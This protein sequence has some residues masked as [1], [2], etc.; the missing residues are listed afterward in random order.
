MSCGYADCYCP[1]NGGHF[2]DAAPNKETSF[3]L[4]QEV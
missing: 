4:V 1:G 3:V 2:V